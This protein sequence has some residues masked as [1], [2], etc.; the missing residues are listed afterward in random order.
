MAG[1]F[2]TKTLIAVAIVPVVVR[3]G[4]EW[5]SGSGEITERI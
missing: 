2:I 3:L 4:T 5:L 1:Q